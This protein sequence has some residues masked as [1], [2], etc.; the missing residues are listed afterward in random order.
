MTAVASYVPGDWVAVSAPGTWL[1]VA[2]PPDHPIVQRC[3]DLMSGTATAEDILDVLVSEGIRSAPHFAFACATGQRRVLARGTATITVT[4]SAGAVE[5]KVAADAGAVWAEEGFTDAV[6]LILLANGSAPASEIELPMASGVTMASR[7]RIRTHGADLIALS[8]RPDTVTAPLS[9]AATHLTDQGNGERSEPED[10]AP[11]AENGPVPGAVDESFAPAA[12]GSGA[13]PAD[14]A[15]SYDFLF[16]ATQ[17]PLPPDAEET[18]PPGE[19]AA[20]ADP[21]LTAGW[22]T[23]APPDLA[24]IDPSPVPVEGSGGGQIIDAV[25]WLAPAVA[26]RSVQAAPPA[27]AASGSSPELVPD[28]MQTIDRAAL[29]AAEPAPVGPTV[30]AGHCPAGHLSPPYA[31]TCRVCRAPMPSDRDGFEISRPALGVIRLADGGSVTLDRG[32]L[33]GRAPETPAGAE[34]RPHLVR[35]VSPENDVSRN[36]AQIVIDGWH[37]YIKDLGS[38]NGTVVTLPGRAPVRLRPDDLQLLDHGSSITLADEV[39]VTFEVTP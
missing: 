2:L 29:L 7:I 30:L 16:G 20:T 8:T 37:V 10:E 33:F 22:S 21:G 18:G 24:G 23:M 5:L 6:D 32:V 35:L 28:V 31:A 14:P 4:D 26:P 17:R 3:W 39:T 36:H 13:A 9:E 34:E 15:G 11:R 12:T 25:P 1:L 27:P 19:P 38:T